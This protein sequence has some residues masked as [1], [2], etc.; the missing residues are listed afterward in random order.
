MTVCKCLLALYHLC[1]GGKAREDIHCVVVSVSSN[2]KDSMRMELC[3]RHARHRVACALHVLGQRSFGLTCSPDPAVPMLYRRP[4]LRPAGLA[5][6]RT[7]YVVHVSMKQ[8]DNTLAMV[9]Q[10]ISLNLYF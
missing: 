3:E 4:T 7:L 9:V 8:P 1:E 5:H 6:D 10:A 2:T